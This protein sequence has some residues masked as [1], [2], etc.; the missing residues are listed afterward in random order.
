[1]LNTKSFCF[2][3]ESAGTQRRATV[4]ATHVFTKAT[5]MKAGGEDHLWRATWIRGS[6]CGIQHNLSDALLWTFTKQFIL[7]SLRPFWVLQRPVVEIKSTNK[8][9][10]KSS[11]FALYYQKHL[12]LLKRDKTKLSFLIF[13]RLLETE[14]RWG[15]ALCCAR[16]EGCSACPDT[17]VSPKYFCRSNFSFCDLVTF[18]L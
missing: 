12:N 18:I 16:F 6:L 4:P 9:E 2:C 1:M 8:A 15:S 7:Q 14:V 5:A 11:L 17:F 13:R 10:T 3:T